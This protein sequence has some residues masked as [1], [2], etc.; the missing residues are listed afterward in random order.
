[1]LDGR[2]RKDTSRTLSCSPS[3]NWHSQTTSTS[4]PNRRRRI[5]WLRSR[6]TFRRSLACQKALLLAGIDRPFLQECLCQKH[7]CTRR[8]FFFAGN[9][10][11]GQPGKLRRCK[12]NRNPSEC[13]SLRTTS[14]GVVFLAR[15]RRII[16][17]RSAVVNLSIVL[18]ACPPAARE[19]IHGVA[20]AWPTPNGEEPYAA[21]RS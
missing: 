3:C 11:S 4:H 12:R 16:S 9:T 5:R 19:I 21:W 10:K 8:A 14:S 17:E 6:S 7:P 15:T 2:E 13:S 18:P 20:S 1:V